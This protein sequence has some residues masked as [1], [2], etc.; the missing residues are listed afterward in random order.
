MHKLAT[1]PSDALTALVKRISARL[2]EIEHAPDV[3][4]NARESVARLVET[5]RQATAE[6][7]RRSRKA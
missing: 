7:D 4:A 1:V 3:N 6:L 2:D 5:R